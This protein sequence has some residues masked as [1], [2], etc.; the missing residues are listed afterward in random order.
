M[1]SPRPRTMPLSTGAAVFYL[2]L[3]RYRVAPLMADLLCPVQ[4]P[5]LRTW[6]HLE[7]LA[8]RE[9]RDALK[10]WLTPRWSFP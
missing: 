5:D 10:G 4:A 6:T 1:T 9:D 2:K 7:L 3:L 8:V